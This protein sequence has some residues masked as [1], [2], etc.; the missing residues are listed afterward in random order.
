MLDKA[1]Q[2]LY[3]WYGVVKW[4]VLLSLVLV[5]L[6]PVFLLDLVFPKEY[7]GSLLR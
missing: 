3:Y 7:N 5:V 2:S 4:Y 1:R 6:T